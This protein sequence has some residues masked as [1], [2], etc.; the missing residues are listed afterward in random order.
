M[1]ARVAQYKVQ[2]GQ[3]QETARRAE[4]GMLPIF[5]RQQGFRAYALVL[6]ENDIVFSISAWDSEE[7]ANRAI[8]AAAG[9]VRENLAG[10]VQS[11]EN[12]VG[13][14]AFASTA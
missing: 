6:A 4:A 8:E 7:E 13:E 9:W 11:V 1:Y 10:M 5:K 3:G 12:H 2:P 14:V